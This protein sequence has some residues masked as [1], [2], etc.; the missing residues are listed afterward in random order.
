LLSSPTPDQVRSIAP[1]P[2][3]ARAGE[4]LANRRTW[5]ATGRNDRAAWGLCQGSG[6]SPYQTIVDFAGPAY[7]C[8][9]PSRKFPCKHA[10]GL[11]FLLAADAAAF[12]AAAEPPAWVAEWLASR[13][14]RDARADARAAASEGRAEGRVAEADPA[15]KA[16]RVQA[17]ERKVEA[18]LSDLDRW[19]RDLVRRG[20]AAAK[21]EGYTFWDQAGARL[22][23]AQAASLAREVRTLGAIVNSGAGWADGALERVARLHLIV[24]AYRRL[25]SLPEDL[26]P[27]VRSLVGWTIK[28]DD[29]PPEGA[30]SDRWLV[31]GRTVTSDDRL[32]TARTWLLGEASRRFALHLAFGAGGANP[33]P[34]AMPGWS[35]NGTLVFYPSATPLRAAAGE[36]GD[37][38]P[39]VTSLPAASTIGGAAG[40]FADVLARNP[41]VTSW[42]VVL[43]DVVPIGRDGLMFLRDGSAASIRATPDA[44]AARLLALAGGHRVSVF[45]LWSGSFIRV[46]AAVA[47]GRLVDLG[48]DSEGDGGS[49][50]TP[51]VEAARPPAEGDPWRRLVSTALLGTERSELPTLDL[52]AP[53]GA[54][55]AQPAETRL[56]GAAAVTAASRRAGWEAPTDEGQ[57]PEPAAPDTRQQASA[58][59]SWL[60]RRALEDRPELV[61]E[62]LT[63]AAAANRRPPHDELP[64]L[65]GLAGRHAETR[66]RLAPIL[67]ARAAWL[68]AQ[69]PELAVAMAARV[70]DPA[71][72]WQA[73][74]AAGER[75]AVIAD[76]RASDTAGAREL[77]AAM[78]E[79]ATTEDRALALAELH[80]GLSAD[81]IPLLERGWADTRA[82]VRSAANDLLARIPGSA[83]AILA[84]ETARG[85]LEQVGRFR[86]SLQAQPPAAWNDALARLGVPKKPPQG[87]G[88]RAWWL[89]H[90][91]ARVAPGRWEEWLAADPAALAD[92]AMRSDD[93]RA[94]L[95]GWVEATIRF[96]DG[97]WAAALLEH[98]EIAFGQ[99]VPDLDSLALLDVLEPADR[100]GVAVRLIG[101]GD[102]GAAAAIVAHCP[103]PWSALVSWAALNALARE[104]KAIGVTKAFVELV[105]MAV[106]RLPPEHAEQLETIVAGDGTRLGAYPIF[107][108]YLELID[109]RKRMRAAF[110][111]EEGS[112]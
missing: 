63:H 15:A 22:V 75:A 42:P 95:E 37:A 70:E 106:R 52:A 24:E 112:R 13:Q 80:A 30:V 62:W 20:L 3:A 27:D 43:G 54:L 48:T 78:W 98:K 107:R 72:A 39:P 17:R 81:D 84:D 57:L 47:D 29:L 46:L 67:G 94:I 10:L 109:F 111:A 44:L 86:P 66:E 7:K 56:L 82:E 49:V 65:L 35:F 8:S 45:G 21:S 58:Q 108:D 68:A 60:L 34:L 89:R 25:D 99:A 110:A 19:L 4:A 16:K 93:A 104:G 102:T 18:G 71:T 40:S 53:V 59:A 2:G 96:R 26:R 12:P 61:A 97:R 31:L 100:D 73:A 32:T 79:D 103:A 55:A 33:V 1:D 36:V 88:E 90:L 28:D 92:R 87:T 83:F 9:C 74:S 6:A 5:S 50:W 69:L 14:E 105:R 41:F 51:P 77:L 85:T 76:L 38:G 101:M 11:M 64:R 23:D 91:L